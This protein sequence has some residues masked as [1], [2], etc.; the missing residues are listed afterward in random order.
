MKKISI[1]ILIFASIL[2]SNAQLFE[3]I[4]NMEII[5]DLGYSQ[6]CAWGDYNNDGNLDLYVTNSWTNDNNLFYKNNGNGTFTKIVEGEIANDGGNSNGCTWGDYNNDGFVDLFVANVNNQNN[7]F[8]KNN[9]DET[10]TKISQSILSTNQGWSYGCSWGDY[11][12]DGFLDLYVANYYEQKN[13]LYH[14]NGDETFTKIE[15]GEIVNDENKSQNCIWSDL[16]NDGFLDLFVANN[17]INCL[18]ANNQNG[19]F[20][21]IVAGSIVEENANSYGASIADYNN[22]GLLDVFIPNWDG[23]NFLYKNLGNF[24]FE[25]TLDQQIVNERNNTEGSSWGD[26]NNDGY[27]DL[28]ITNDGINYLYTNNGNETFILIDDLNINTDG[29]NSNGCTLTDYNN[30]GFLDLFIA[31]GGNQTNLLYYNKKNTNN[32]LKIKCIGQNHNVS[33]VGT[34]IALLATINGKKE[35]QYHEITAQSGGGYGSQSGFIA[36][37]GLGNASIVETII[38]MWNNNIQ[39]FINTPV[40]QLLTVIE[41]DNETI[42]DNPKIRVFPNPFSDYFNIEY[43]IYNDAK[44]DLKIFNSRGQLIKNCINNE[45]QLRGKYSV[46]LQNNDFLFSSGIYYYVLMVDNVRYSDKI[47]YE[48]GK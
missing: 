42:F 10:F 24:I 12:N 18:Y 26:Y 39:L 41:S 6:G 48:K 3:L 44:I 23:K 31:N 2:Q 19:S 46:L 47:I 30:D 25:K 1:F 14:N 35:W 13:F 5:T 16:N 36:N 8:Y 22:D 45:A 20:T 17:G 28:F 27:K 11:D 29:T 7:F 4:E 15:Q 40:N 9:G 38:I 43:Y 21:K 33:A 32:W 34:K 37:F